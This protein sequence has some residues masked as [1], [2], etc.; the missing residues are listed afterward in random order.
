[1]KYTGY[2]KFKQQYPVWENMD[3]HVSWVLLILNINFYAMALSWKIFIK[4]NPQKAVKM[5]AATWNTERKKFD[6]CSKQLYLC[7]AKSTY[8]IGQT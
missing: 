8:S 5:C 4:S 6:L 2:Q 1:M 7:K 3:F